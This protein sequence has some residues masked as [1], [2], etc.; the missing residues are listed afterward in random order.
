LPVKGGESLILK[1]K[2][3]TILYLCLILCGL[4]LAY[5]KG[6]EPYLKEGR[7]LD[8]ELRAKQALLEKSLNLLAQKPVLAK[9]YRRIKN[10]LK[11]N[12]SVDEY[13]SMFMVELEKTVRQSGIKS[14]AS[15][16]PLPPQEEKDYLLLP[17]EISFDART[18]QLVNLV[19]ELIRQ[20][21]LSAVEKLVVE[22]DLETPGLIKGR[23]TVA[24]VYLKGAEAK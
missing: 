20:N 23:I 13:S 3:K 1:K 9:E 16:N 22:S 11:S 19:Y 21:S 24:A 14:I 12:F 18:P 7:D 15:L 6:F 2:E 10:Q 5:V 8:E 17:A 4:S